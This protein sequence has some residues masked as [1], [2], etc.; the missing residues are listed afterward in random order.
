[1]KKSTAEKTTK[2]V[3]TP[4]P[5]KKA[6]KA[7]LPTKSPKT[8]AAV[9][10]KTKA[11]SPEPKTTAKTVAAVKKPRAPKSTPA[12]QATTPQPIADSPVV[13]TTISA[14]IDVGFGNFLTL[15]GEGAGLSWEQ[16]TPLKCIHQD[17][18]SLT[19]PESTNPIVCKFLLNDQ[20]WNTGENFTILPGSDVVLDPVF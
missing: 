19:L 14:A 1:M 4:A 2:S 17:R 11:T 10:S 20:V 16:G 6:V 18:W 7:S 3:K 5:A 15:R 13:T 12:A 9:R 8:S